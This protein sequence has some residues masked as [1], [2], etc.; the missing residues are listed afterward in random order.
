MIFDAILNRIPTPPVRLNPDLPPE[1]ERIITRALEKDRTLRYQ[2]AA[3]I[4][5]ELLRLKRD[6]DTSRAMVSVDNGLNEGLATSRRSVEPFGGEKKAPSSPNQ[7]PA[8]GDH[9]PCHEF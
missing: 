2:H 3:E 4:R 5:A 6:T 1:L 8:A 9:A 7:P